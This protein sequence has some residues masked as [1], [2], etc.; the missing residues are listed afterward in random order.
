MGL[1]FDRPT[2]VAKPGRGGP[3]DKPA[4]KGHHRD[5]LLS[6]NILVPSTRLELVTYRV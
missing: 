2:T 5:A 6:L 1:R 3:S 4:K